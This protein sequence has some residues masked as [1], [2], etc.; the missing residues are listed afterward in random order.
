MVGHDDELVAAGI[1]VRELLAITI[2]EDGGELGAAQGY[3]AESI[4]ATVA[5]TLLATIAQAQFMSQ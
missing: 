1:V 2:T 3:Q 4:E 5:L